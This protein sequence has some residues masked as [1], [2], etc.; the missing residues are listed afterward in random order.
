[1]NDRTN[2][3]E[4]NAR[5]MG[6][7][8]V[9]H[10]LWAAAQLTPGEGIEDGTRRVAAILSRAPAQAAEPVAIPAGWKLMPIQPTG[11][12]KDAGRWA[13]PVGTGGPRTASAIK[14]AMIDQIP[15]PPAQ[16]DAWE[17]LTDEQR[18][19][20]RFAASWFD[21][22]V[23]PDTPYKGYSKA[24]RALLAAHPGRRAS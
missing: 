5:E 15:H 8:G 4:S 10:E 9:A 24:L 17:G 2:L 16:A 13:L 21:Q 11:V 7:E 14:Q 3:V 18:E 22:S 23:L 12:M 6:T 1:M 20:I 19:A